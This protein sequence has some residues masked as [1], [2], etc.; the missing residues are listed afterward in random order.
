M[1]KLSVLFPP[2]AAPKAKAVPMDFGTVLSIS[3]NSFHPVL[4]SQGVED[5]AMA[6]DYLSRALPH[7]HEVGK[8]L[9]NWPIQTKEYFTA[10]ALLNSYIYILE[11]TLQKPENELLADYAKS[12]VGGAQ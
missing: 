1:Q 10:L 8:K 6:S 9:K 3:N 4:T 2:V 12:K 7:L 11:A 5:F